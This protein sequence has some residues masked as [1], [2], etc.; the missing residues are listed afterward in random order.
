MLASKDGDGSRQKEFTEALLKR[1]HTDG[2]WGWQPE[3]AES[4]PF[5][6]SQVLYA[7]GYMGEKSTGPS[8]QKAREYLL[9]TQNETGTW[10]VAIKTFST[11]KKTDTKTG[12]EVYTYWTTAWA[13]VAL[14]QTMS[15]ENVSPR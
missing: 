2:G 5:T 13:V 3:R 15:D 12:D 14:L 7:L 10:P 4:D 6:T 9:K 8:L 1:Q 11:T